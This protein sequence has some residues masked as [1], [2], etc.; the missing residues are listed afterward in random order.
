MI[1]RHDQDTQTLHSELL[2]L[3]LAN[4]SARHWPHL[5]GSFVS[6]QVRGGTYIYFQYSDPGGGKR[7]WSIGPG[8]AAVE[9]LV[10][11]WRQG[12]QLQEQELAGVER[13]ARLFAA[14]GPGKVPHAVARV[15]RALADAGVFR[16][17]AMLVGTHAFA[18][19][20]NLLGVRWIGASWSTEDVDVAAPLELATPQLEADVPKAL[21]SLQMGFVPVPA[22]DPRHPSTSFKVRGKVLRV[23]L[24]TPGSDRDTAPIYIPRLRAAAAPIKYL[25]LLLADPVPAAAVN[26][27]AVLVMVPQPA[28]FA[29]H[30]LLVSQTR[31][32]VQQTKVGKDQLQAGLLL[33]VLA[34]DRPDDVR[35]AAAAFQAAGPTVVAKVLRGA[36]AMVKQCPDAR[37]AAEL[38]AD[39]LA[40]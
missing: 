37:G 33:E 20:G 23:D 13:L 27:G 9:A 14:S 7:Q 8:S 31:S 30:K 2:A 22:F 18:L 21:E 3:L 5:D 38:L 36:K 39:A 19:L 16:L 17:G 4:E 29:L 35:S 12:R 28:R 1:Q 11:A 40:G 32:V 34:E 6:K 15:L 10:A 24:L 25:S 26:G